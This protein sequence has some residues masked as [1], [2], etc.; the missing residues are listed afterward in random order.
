MKTV[1]AKTMLPIITRSWLAIPLLAAFLTV[2]ADRANAQLTPTLRTLRVADDAPAPP[3]GSPADGKGGP[4]IAGPGGRAR[5]FLVLRISEAL[6]LNDEQTLRVAAVLRGLGQKRA[7]LVDDRAQV[8]SHL[9]T[10]IAKQPPNAQTLDQLSAQ[11]QEIDRKIALLPDQGFEEIAHDLTPEQRARL[12]ILKGQLRDQLRNERA[13]RAGAAGAAGS[14]GGA[15][16]P[17]GRRRWWRSMQ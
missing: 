15:A 4:A 7:R 5:M 2:G 13:R 1:K 10:E 3:T 12:V 6:H 14:D 9:E 16:P 8:E 17:A 11:A